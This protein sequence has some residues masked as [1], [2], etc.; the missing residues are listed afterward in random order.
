MRRFAIAGALAL[1]CACV[2]VGNKFDPAKADQLTPGTS[3]IADATRLLGPISAETNMPD[4][5]KLLQWQYSRGTAVGTGSGAHMAILFDTQGRMV[6]IAHR[7]T[8][9][10]H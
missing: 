6:R 1:L 9:K 4:G 10:V 3:T 8:T 5:T 7:S 2:T